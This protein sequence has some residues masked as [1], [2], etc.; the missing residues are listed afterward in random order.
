MS[1][2]P[3]LPAGQRL[4]VSSL[5]QFMAAETPHP[6]LEKW[7]RSRQEDPG[8]PSVPLAVTPEIEREMLAPFAHRVLDQRPDRLIPE[9]MVMIQ[10][11]GDNPLLPQILMVPA[12]TDPRT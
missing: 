3:P 1:I 12:G 8:R 6:V 10:E 4:R 7:S 9:A 11:A 2:F 5:L